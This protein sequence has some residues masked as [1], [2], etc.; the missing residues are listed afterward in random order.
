[1]SA[2][3]ELVVEL[4]RQARVVL[5]LPGDDGQPPERHEVRTPA[6]I[7]LGDPQEVLKRHTDILP[8][9]IITVAYTKSD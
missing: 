7:R 6:V 2:D 1:M 4:P 5:V 8:K 3:N 9:V